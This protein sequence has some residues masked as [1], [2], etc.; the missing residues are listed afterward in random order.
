MA[1]DV[2]PVFVE[3]SYSKHRRRDS[4][5]LHPDIVERL[6]SWLTKRN[7]KTDDEIL[8]TLNI[9]THVEQEEQIAAINSLPGIW[10]HLLKYGIPP[11]ALRT[12]MPVQG[13]PIARTT[14]L[15]W[16]AATPR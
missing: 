5:I 3:A 15:P 1:S 10:V 2:P 12:E 4:Q 8:L 9:Y 14:P 11:L 13:G 6:K 7:P 16:V